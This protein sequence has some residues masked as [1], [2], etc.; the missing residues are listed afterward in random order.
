VGSYQR[1]LDSK[2]RLLFP[3]KL[4]RKLPA[5]GGQVT[6]YVMLLDDHLGLFPEEAFH[7]RMKEQRPTGFGADPDFTALMSFAEEATLDANNRLRLTASHLKDA[8]LEREVVLVGAGDHLQI[9]SPEA[10]A[11]MQDAYR[12]KQGGSGDPA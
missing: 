3:A 12:K 8:G 5:A 1:S 2:G 4:L 11:A 6:L 10:L 7:D 9:W